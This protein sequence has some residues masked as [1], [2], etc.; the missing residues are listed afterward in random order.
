MRG[1]HQSLVPVTGGFPLQ[2]ANNADLWCFFVVSLRLC[3]CCRFKEKNCILKFCSVINSRVFLYQFIFDI[4]TDYVMNLHHCNPNKIF[5][6]LS[7]DSSCVCHLKPYI[8][9]E[10]NLQEITTGTPWT[11][12]VN[13]IKI[14]RV[15]STSNWCL[16]FKKISQYFCRG[17]YTIL[18]KLRKASC[19]RLRCVVVSKRF[20]TWVTTFPWISKQNIWKKRF[21]DQNLWFS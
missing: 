10:W 4:R 13:L 20:K 16:C 9:F 6:F 21:Q 8:W 2:R 14:E 5:L 12:T 18:E 17:V 11:H 15:L 3:K 7:H 1:I 19:K